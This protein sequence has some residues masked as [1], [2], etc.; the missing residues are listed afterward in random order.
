MSYRC[1]RCSRWMRFQWANPR[2]KKYFCPNCRQVLFVNRT[3]RVKQVR[4]RKWLFL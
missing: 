3:Q 2:R 1:P 4:R